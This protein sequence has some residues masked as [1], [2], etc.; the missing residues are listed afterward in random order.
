VSTAK[1]GKI[2]AECLGIKWRPSRPLEGDLGWLWPS[3]GA[4]RQRSAKH[5]IVVFGPWRLE[6]IDQQGRGGMPHDHRCQARTDRI[7]VWLRKAETSSLE[8]AECCHLPRGRQVRDWTIRLIA[9]GWSP[10]AA[11]LDAVCWG[12]GESL[13]KPSLCDVTDQDVSA[14]RLS[15]SWY[16]GGKWLIGWWTG[17]LS[18]G[19]SPKSSVLRDFPWDFPSTKTSSY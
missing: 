9:S 7:R 12:S 2:H 14:W 3:S 16:E 11:H 1:S 15:P 17:F 18:H 19:G 5:T 4:G 8:L 10:S 13:E 6:N